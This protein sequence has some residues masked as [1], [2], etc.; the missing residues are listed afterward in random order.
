MHFPWE[1]AE[2]LAGATA[3][4]PSAGPFCREL[5]VA[6]VN[7]EGLPVA[8]LGGLPAGGRLR[9]VR[10]ARVGRQEIATWV[11]EVAAEGGG[12]TEVLLYRDKQHQQVRGAKDITLA[13]AVDAARV[14]CA[15]AARAWG[16]APRVVSACYSNLN[17]TLVVLPPPPPAYALR[18]RCTPPQPDLSRVQ[19]ALA[20][21]QAVPA[22]APYFPGA[23]VGFINLRQCNGGTALRA[24]V[25]FDGAIREKNPSLTVT[26]QPKARVKGAHTL[27][28]LALIRAAVSAIFA[29]DAQLAP[30][31]LLRPALP[32][33]DA[34][35]AAWLG[36]AGRLARGAS[37]ANA[38]AHSLLLEQV[39][40][41]VAEGLAFDAAAPLTPAEAAQFFAGCYRRLLLAR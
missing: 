32:A 41:R 39:Q 15:A 13:D 30:P 29:A 21:F 28:Q 11:A 38:R 25:V 17:A 10:D 2:A 22:R 14:I 1:D 34:A 23:R 7:T 33:S 37:R 36:A 27:R 31:L 40:L 12:T 35:F 19:A 4:L 9:A 5:I 3:P 16:G 24:E 18:P 20:A 26:A 6:R 8:Q